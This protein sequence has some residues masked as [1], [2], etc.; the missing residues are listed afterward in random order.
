M[1]ED[2]GIRADWSPARLHH[3]GMLTSSLEEFVAVRQ[4]LVDRGASDG[5]V[6]DF[7]MH[8]SVL[9]TD[10]D[11]GMLDVML[12]TQVDRGLLPFAVEAHG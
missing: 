8:V 9:A 12:P 4:R 3:V 11:G 10:P 7:G 6:E 1:F 2:G 5:R